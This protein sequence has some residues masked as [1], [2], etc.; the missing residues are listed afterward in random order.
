[1]SYGIIVTLLFSLAFL[2]K[3]VEQIVK[4]GIVG[5]INEIGESFV[6]WDDPSAFFF[7]YIIGYIIIWWSPLWGSVIIITGCLVFL[8]THIDNIWNL[9]F[10]IPT[11]LVGL[12]YLLTAYSKKKTR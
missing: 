4:I 12:L 6:K 11:F 8:F 3:L 7:T 1:M 5:V 10:F 2:P 9:I